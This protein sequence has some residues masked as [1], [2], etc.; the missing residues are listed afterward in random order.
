MISLRLEDVR[1]WTGG[2]VTNLDVG[3]VVNKLSI[4]SREAAPGVLFIALPGS[5]TD[6]HAFVQDVWRAGGVAM[7]R[8]DFPDTDGPTVRVDSPLEAMGQLLR[9]Y[10]ASRQVTVVGVTGS[11]GKTSVKEL[12]AA[13][14]R[15]KF[16]TSFSL[17]NYNTAIGLPLSFFAGPANTTHFVAEMGMS[18]PGEIRRLTEIAP[19]D[20]AVIS[21]IGPSHLEKLGSMEAIQAAKGEILEGLK[22]EGL[23]VLNH[24]N[25][26][27]RELGERTPRRV[28]WFGTSSGLAGRVLSSEVQADHTLM[29]LEILGQKATIRLPWLGAHQA[30][31]VAAALLIGRHLGLALDEAVAGVEAVDANRS[32]IRVVSTG[33]WTLLADVYNASPLSTQAALDV[34]KSRPGRHVAVIGDMLELGSEEIRGHRQVGVYALGRADVLLGVGARARHVVEAA[35]STGVQAEWVATRDEALDWLLQRL[36]DGDVVLLKASR[37]MQFEWLAHKLEERGRRS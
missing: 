5:N 34:L 18:A 3:G 28:Q 36:Q 17:G 7:V 33:C 29:V 1:R 6:G 4:D 8:R 13:V 11:V 19:P 35:Q 16:S 20:V 27:V 32:R 15:Q 22:P 2:E 25:H 31:N 10:L 24:D 37:G 30:H 23:A 14:L 9:G 26:W 12:T 21:T